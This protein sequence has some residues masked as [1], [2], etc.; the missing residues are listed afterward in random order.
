MFWSPKL[1][2]LLNASPD[3]VNKT[4]YFGKLFRVSGF[5]FRVSGFGFRV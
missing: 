2:T 4:D 1:T 5:G 3:W